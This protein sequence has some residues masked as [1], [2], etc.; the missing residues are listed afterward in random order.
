MQRLKATGAVSIGS[1][2]LPGDYILQIVVT[3][4]LAKKNQRVATQFVQFE[5]VG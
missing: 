5:I 4:P 1:Q 3:D 2:M